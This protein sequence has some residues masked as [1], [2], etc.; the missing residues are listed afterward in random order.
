MTQAGYVVFCVLQF[1]PL[2][3]QLSG[4]RVNGIV[5]L[6][7]SASGGLAIVVGLGL[8]KLHI[9]P[10]TEVLDATTHTGRYMSNRL[11][12]TTIFLQFLIVLQMVVVALAAGAFL[13]LHDKGFNFDMRTPERTA[14]F[15]W[16]V[17]GVLV[18]W[19]A[20]TALALAYVIRKRRRHEALPK[21]DE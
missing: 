9:Q 17:F 5:L 16:V 13:V 8:R 7:M 6:V 15:V 20:M 19:T 14:F 1:V 18:F 3:L 2:M 12:N 10:A 4:A 21:S 11:W